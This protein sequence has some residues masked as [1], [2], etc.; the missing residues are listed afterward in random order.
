MLSPVV[1]Q[2]KFLSVV[3]K[4]HKKEQYHTSDFHVI[5]L[6]NTDLKQIK[7]LKWAGKSCRYEPI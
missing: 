6:N 5:Q 4:L 1:K 2:E 7:N 3:S